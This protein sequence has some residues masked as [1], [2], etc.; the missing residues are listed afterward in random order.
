MIAK[1][2][3]NGTIARDDV[4]A[5]LCH[6]HFSQFPQVRMAEIVGLNLDKFIR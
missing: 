2:D 3:M 5:E 1:Y 4:M 6:A